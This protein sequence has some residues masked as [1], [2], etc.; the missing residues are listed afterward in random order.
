MIKVLVT[1]GSGTLGLPSPS[2]E[3]R[4]LLNSMNSADIELAVASNVPESR[5]RARFTSAGLPV[6]NLLVTSQDVGVRKP[7]PRFIEEIASQSGYSKKQIAY[8]GDND[9]TDILCAINAGVLPIAARYSNPNIKYGI[10]VDH[11]RALQRYLETFGGQQGEYFAWSASEHCRDTNTPI[12]IRALIYDQGRINRDLREVLKHGQQVRLGSYAADLGQVIFQ[13]L[14]SSTYQSGLT[15]EFNY[16]TV[17]PGHQAG[18][19]NPIL[20]EFSSI[21]SRLFRTNYIPDLIV[22]HKDAPKSQYQGPNRSILDQLRTIHINPDYRDRVQGKGILVLDDYTTAGYSLETA[23]QMLIRGGASEVVAVAIAKFR[24]SHAVSQ[25]Q[26]EFDP[27]SPL[28]IED[29]E[30][31]AIDHQGTMVTSVDDYF[32]ETILPVYEV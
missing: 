19:V 3:I 16:V 26:K 23:R 9:G 27:Y 28:E 10:P 7:S 30:V 5:V 6:P 18:S 12:D 24:S 2:A 4:N 8:L 1:D 17:Y 20:D 11:P 21:L 31:N 22:R 32:F 29:G 13:Y 15:Q 25:I 14:V